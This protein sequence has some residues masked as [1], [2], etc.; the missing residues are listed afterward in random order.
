MRICSYLSKSRFQLPFFLCAYL[1]LRHL[2][3]KSG[4]QI[5]YR[6]EIGMGFYI[7][8]FGTVIV[9]SD[10]KLGKNINLSPGV[11]IGMANRGKNKGVAVLEDNIYVGP[12]AKIVG[13][14][15]IGNNVAIGANAVV[16]KD[17]PDNVSVAGVPAKVLSFA[18]SENYVN[19]RV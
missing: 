6:T 15:H 17:L 11:V 14:V 2:S 16:T 3:Y 5:S 9:N 7:G 10:A 1:M 4:F 8:H 18:G 13:A 12:G 19:R